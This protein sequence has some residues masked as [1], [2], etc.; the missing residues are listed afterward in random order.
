MIVSKPDGEVLLSG[1]FQWVAP[2]GTL[3]SQRLL[4]DLSGSSIFPRVLP[5]DSPESAPLEMTGHIF[6]FACER[7]EGGAQALLDVEVSVTGTGGQR[8]DVFHRRYRVQSTPFEEGSSSAFAAGMSSA[9]RTLSAE[10]SRDL[11]RTAESG[12]TSSEK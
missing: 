1:T 10:L 4:D 11:C 5:E 6:S 3:L 12:G 9:V 8:R 7:K 2:P